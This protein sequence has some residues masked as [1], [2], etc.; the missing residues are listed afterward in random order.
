MRNRKIL[1][2]DFGGE[3][4]VITLPAILYVCDKVEV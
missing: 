4:L 2:R 3:V 1:V